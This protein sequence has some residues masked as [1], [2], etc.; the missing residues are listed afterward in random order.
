VKNKILSVGYASF[1]I[2]LAQVQ[3]QLLLAK[4]LL[5]EGF[6]VIVLNRYGIHNTH[7][8]LSAKGVFEGV[9]YIYCSGTSVRPD[10][11]FKRNFL[12]FRGLFTEINYFRELSKSGQL[13]GALVSTNRFHN[14]L[15]YFLM[16]KLFR[17]P[18]TVDNVEYYTS[19]GAKKMI[20]KIEFNLYDKYYYYL[21][22]N[23]IC[24]SDFLISKVGKS[25]KDRILKIPVI[26][27][28]DKFNN[29]NTSN[30]LVKEKYFL[31]CGSVIYSEVIEFVISAFEKAEL[32]NVRL[33][34]VTK[35]NEDLKVKI[36]ASKAF[37]SLRVMTDLA[38]NDLINLYK[39]SE[40]LIIPMRDTDQDKAR[41]PH[42]ISEYCASGR[43]IITNK[44]GEIGNYFNAEN[45]FLC[46]G[47]NVDEYASAMLKVVSDPELADRVAAKSYKTGME[48]FNYKTYQKQL[49]NFFVKE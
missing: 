37:D 49:K 30:R 25:G 16:G 10:N 38:Y 8:G 44:I 4:A 2:G 47:Y 19:T 14:V 20:N 7:D 34:L 11:Y 9:S 12:K 22:D 6:E 42:K 15:F 26:T 45:A 3:R 5:T 39:N 13:A 21:T 23:V 29:H 35:L 31:F 24:I 27:D 32:S 18:I 41:F 36:E 40:A 17:T 28:F 46:T 48:V 33:V 43:P 1:P